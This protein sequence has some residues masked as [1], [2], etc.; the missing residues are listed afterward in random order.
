MTIPARPLIVFATRN[1]GKLAQLAH[2]ANAAGFELVGLDQYPGAPEVEET[3]DTFEANARLKAESAL[4]ATGLPS[5]ADDSGLAVD[6]L[7]GEPGVQSARYAGPGASDEDNNRLLL[8]NMTGQTDRRARYVCVLAWAEAGKPVRFFRGETPGTIALALHG[9][10]QGFGY[11]PLF[12][13]DELGM[14]FSEAGLEAK[15][16][17]SHRGR[18]WRAWLARSANKPGEPL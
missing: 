3:G 14:A 1:R 18:A 10:G 9:G 4:R 2:A 13:S 7:G 15:M 8:K 12:V 6:I 5:L 17:I 11:D 16:A